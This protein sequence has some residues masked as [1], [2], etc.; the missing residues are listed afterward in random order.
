MTINPNSSQLI[1]IKH[2]PSPLMIIYRDLLIKPFYKK[3]LLISLKNV[4][5]NENILAI[6][7]KAELRTQI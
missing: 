4:K 5:L 3:E 6:T 7:E 2:P 1:A